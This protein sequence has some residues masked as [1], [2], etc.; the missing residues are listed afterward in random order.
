MRLTVLLCSLLVPLVAVAA[1][2][3]SALRFEPTRL[4]LGDALEGRAVQATLRVRNVGDAMGE[5]VALTASCG[6]TRVWAESRLLMPGE[7]TRVHVLIDTTA[8]RGS[9]RKWIELTD[10]KGGKARAW[11]TLNVRANPHLTTNKG[12]FTGAC[13]RCHFDPAQGKRSGAALYRALCAMCHGAHGEGRYAPRLAGIRDRAWLRARIAQGTGSRYMPGFS[14]AVGGPLDDTQLDAL[15]GWILALD[16]GVDS[17]YK[18]QPV[19]E[20]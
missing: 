8:K 14:R 17:R 3:M 4:D 9:T 20:E 6:C 16:A 1:D 10:A 19:E 15:L 11:L 18:S 7:F 12:L 5:I 13:R 2:G